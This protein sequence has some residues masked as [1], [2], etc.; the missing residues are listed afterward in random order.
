MLLL[1]LL[2]S[3][4]LVYFLPFFLDFCPRHIISYFSHYGFLGGMVN[5]WITGALNRV[6]V[7]AVT[8]MKW[9]KS[10]PLKPDKTV[11]TYEK[12]QQNHP[13]GQLKEKQKLETV[14]ITCPWLAPSSY[15]FS[16]F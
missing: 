15:L 3:P 9:P 1:A 4:L 14:S 7:L 16:P 13:N 12:Q 8:L 10:A 5:L 11:L 6:E 2:L